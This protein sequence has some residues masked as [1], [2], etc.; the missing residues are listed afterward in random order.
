MPPDVVRIS[1]AAGGG[2]G[3]ASETTGATGATAAGAGE[4][5]GSGPNTRA[6]L[7]NTFFGGPATML[8]FSEPSRSA[9]LRALT[10]WG[11]GPTYQ[12]SPSNGLRPPTS[13]SMRTSASGTLVSATIDPRFS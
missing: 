3:E 4:S 1:L 6:S 9:V 10:M 5:S 12:F 13:S 11:P 2:A 7:T 8:T